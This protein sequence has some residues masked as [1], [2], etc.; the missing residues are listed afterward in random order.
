MGPSCR[1]R[2]EHPHGSQPGGYRRRIRALLPTTEARAG[3]RAVQEI[4]LLGHV[5]IPGLINARTHSPMTLLRGLAD[6]LPLM[7]WLNQHI[8]PAEQRWVD[9]EFVR[10]G[11]RLAA[12]ARA[13][14]DAGMRAVA[15]MILVDFPTQLEA[16]EIAAIAHASAHVVHCPESNL[17]LAA[18]FCPVARFLAVGV[19]VTLG[20]DGAASNNDLDMMGELRTSS[21][22]GQGR[23][24]LPGG[25]ARLYCPA[26]GDHERGAGPRHRRRDR[27]P[28]DRQISGHSGPRPAGPGYPTRLQSDLSGRLRGRTRS[29]PTGV[30]RRPAARSVTASPPPWTRRPS[31]TK[32]GTGGRGS[33]QPID[34]WGVLKRPRRAVLEC[35]GNLIPGTCRSPRCLMYTTLIWFFR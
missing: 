21:P 4:E 5:L 23:G 7:T 2:R 31:W 33:P 18:G 35:G 14:A 1:C 6:D 19:N 34:P 25:A 27:L 11:T 26:D 24:R 28:R 17:K 15:G 3:I 20:T 32:R 22:A 16:L 12:F 30:G 8:W 10:A 9:P 29:G 13:A